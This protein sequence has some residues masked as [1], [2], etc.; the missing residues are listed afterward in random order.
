MPICVWRIFKW[1]LGIPPAFTKLLCYGIYQGSR[2][3][4]PAAGAMSCYFQASER[5]S[6][7]PSCLL[8]KQQHVD[9]KG[10][11][12]WDHSTRGWGE[13]ELGDFPKSKMRRSGT[14]TGSEKT[15]AYGVP[16]IKEIWAWRITEHCAFIA[17]KCTLTVDIVRKK[18]VCIA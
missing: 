14:D 16:E 6:C 3:Q 4:L 11:Q 17:K 2:S 12:C 15:G 1:I 10:W 5:K 7:K 18:M 8:F 9:V 13:L